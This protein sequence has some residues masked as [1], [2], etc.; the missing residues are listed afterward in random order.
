LNLETGKQV[1]TG[2]RRGGKIKYYNGERKDVV[3]VRMNTDNSH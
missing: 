2:L 3:S 1:R